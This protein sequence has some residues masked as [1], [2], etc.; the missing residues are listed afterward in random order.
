MVLLHPI[1]PVACENLA[2]FL[3]LSEDVFSW[4]EIE[5]PIYNFVKN[6]KNYVP[7]FLEPRQ[8]FFKKHHTQLFSS[9]E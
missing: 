8:D 7:K 9:E 1:T 6:K 5:M 3:E 2:Q 4:D